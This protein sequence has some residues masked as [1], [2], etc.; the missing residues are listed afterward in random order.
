MLTK[1]WC[2][3]N[4]PKAHTQTHTFSLCLCECVCAVQVLKKIGRKY[5][6]VRAR[7]YRIPVS[8]TSTKDSSSASATPFAYA[9]PQNS[10]SDCLLAALYLSKLHKKN[11]RIILFNHTN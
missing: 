8:T 7:I 4:R 10:V 5:R 2:C 9:I 6:S 1:S 11:T 3:G